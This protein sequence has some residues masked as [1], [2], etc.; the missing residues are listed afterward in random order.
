MPKLPSSDWLADSMKNVLDSDAHRKIFEGPQFRIKQA[1][2]EV[3]PAELA[4]TKLLEA[5]DKLENLGLSKSSLEVLAIVE[6]LTDEIE[7]VASLDPEQLKKLKE[8]NS[9]LNSFTG[10]LETPAEVKQPLQTAG[11]GRAGTWPSMMRHP[12]KEA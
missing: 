8:I 9:E 4:I 6:G 12:G 2:V 11:P 7:K 3:S 1:Q 10:S 5:S